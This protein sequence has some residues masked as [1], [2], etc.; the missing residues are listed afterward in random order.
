MNGKPFVRMDSGHTRLKSGQYIFNDGE[1]K[2][3]T[4][5]VGSQIEFDN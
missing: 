4:R 3:S 2:F 5:D 1:Y